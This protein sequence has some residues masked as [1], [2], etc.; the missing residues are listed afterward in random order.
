LKKIEII[1]TKEAWRGFKNKLNSPCLKALNTS[2]NTL[3]N[4][5][6]TTCLFDASELKFGI[7]YCYNGGSVGPNESPSASAFIDTL[8]E[9]SANDIATDIGINKNESIPTGKASSTKITTK[10]TIKVSV[11]KRDAKRVAR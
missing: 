4:R 2:L 7:A 1:T 11:G 3:V 10:K 9:L 5:A 6:A 8:S